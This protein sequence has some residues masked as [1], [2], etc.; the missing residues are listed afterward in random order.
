MTSCARASLPRMEF[1]A[2]GL[3]VRRDACTFDSKYY[4]F[5]RAA[6]RLVSLVRHANKTAL[7]SAIYV[8]YTLR[9]I[10]TGDDDDDDPRADAT[11]LTGA[12]TSS[13]INKLLFGVRAIARQGTVARRMMMMVVMCVARWAPV[14][15]SS[16]AARA[17][18]IIL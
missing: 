18:S 16:Y 9:L 8:Y 4:T 13:A 12:A 14:C 10:A 7:H 1:S 3:C 15:F 17:L 11:M 2:F 6:L 5:A